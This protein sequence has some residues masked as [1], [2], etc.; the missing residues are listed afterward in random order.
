MEAI[1]T[2]SDNV[3]SVKADNEELILKNEADGKK[4]WSYKLAANVIEE[5]Q[6]INMIAVEKNI[7]ATNDKGNE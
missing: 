1:V 6:D 4:N 7:I 3:V 5:R 2:T